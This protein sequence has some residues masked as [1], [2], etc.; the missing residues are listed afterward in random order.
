MAPLVTLALAPA[1][2]VAWLLYLWAST[3]DRL[4][5][6]HTEENGWAQHTTLMAIPDLIRSVA[7]THPADM[8]QVLALASTGLAVIL[9]VVLVVSRPP[10]MFTV[11]SAAVLIL[12]AT[13]VNPAGIRF[14]FVLTAFPLVVVV[15]R[16]LKD[17]ALAVAV[18]MGS[19][20][21]G[22]ILV[23][24]LMGPALIP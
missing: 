22:V 1:A 24:T 21:M 5:W 13:S 2:I 14:R 4:A 8:T 12:S 7:R 3:G 11:Y 6:V 18:A 19:V 9:L 15:G 16:Y 17:A 10:A 23:V 20:V